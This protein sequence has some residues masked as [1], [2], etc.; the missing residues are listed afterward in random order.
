MP[1]S[2]R[3]F[4]KTTI[5][6]GAGSTL[7]A[8]PAFASAQSKPPAATA[9]A[10]EAAFTRGIGV[11]PGAPGEYFCPTLDIDNTTY[12][13]LALN[14]PAT[15]SSSY[16]Y[17]LTPQLVT[18]GIK[19]ITPPRWISAS[20]STDGVMPKQ[21]RETFLDHWQAN[22][23][24]ILGGQASASIELGGGP[25][26]P[27]A[28]PEVDRIAVFVVIP[29]F[30]S[31][32]KVSITL[33][34]SEDGHSWQ[35][36]GSVTN[37]TPNTET[38]RWPPDLMRGTHILY[39]SIP[40]DKPRRSRFYRVE[41]VVAGA[42]AEDPNITWHLGQIEFYA[43]PN[44]LQIGGPYSFTS[45]WKSA[46]LDE[47]WVAVDLGA[48][49]TFDRVTLHWIARAAAGSLQTS[50]DGETWHTF[51]SLPASAGNI[52][53][54]H[55]APP[56]HARHIRVLMTRPTSPDGYILSEFEVFGRGGP[57]PIPKPAPAPAPTP[58]GRLS[59]AGGNWRLQRENLVEAPGVALSKPTFSDAHWLPA[60]VPGTI[61]T[62]YLNAGAIPDPNF[63]QNQLHISDSFFYA[64]FW[65]RTTFTPPPAGAGQLQ[66]LNFDGI[67]WKAE[68][69]LNGQ[70]LGEIAGGFQRARFNITPHLLPGGDNVLAVRILKNATPGS[71]KQKTFETPGPNG[72]AP[73]ADN[74]T[75]HSSIGWDWIPTI[76]GRNTGIW[77]EVFVETTGTVTLE[78][79]LVSSILTDN[80]KAADVTIRV[81]LV[82]HGSQPA[83]G[84]LQVDFGPIAFGQSV[85]VPP[86]SRITVTLDPS[87]HPKLH[88]EN[89]KLWWPVGYGDPHLYDVSLA[90]D[91]SN[92]SGKYDGFL[93][94]IHLYSDRKTFKAGIRQ[95]TATE[96]GG[97][98]KLFIN[99]R[100]FIPR[101][102]NWGFS[103]SMLR[104]RAREYDAALRY[105][106]EMNFTMIRN[107]VGQIG[108]NAFY[109]ACDRH[110]IVVWQDFWLANPW[111]GPIPDDNALF[112]ANARDTILR[113]RHH[114]SIGLYC[115][116]NEG[117]PPPALETGLRALL[118]ELHPGIHYI[119]SSADDVVSGH[120]PYRALPP[121]T[122]FQHADTKFHS[123]IGM[124][125]IPTLDSVRLMMPTSAM[126]PQGLDWGL[127]D[128]SLNGAQGGRSFRSIID[129]S[130]GGATSAEEWITLAQFVNYEGYRA[131]F[132]AQ[133]R[134][135]MGVLLWMSHPCWP[136]FV[137]QTYDFYLEPTAAYFGCKKASEPLHIQWN[138]LTGF[139]E[140]V[141]LSAGSLTGLTAKVEILNLDGTSIATQTNSLDSPEDSVAPCIK[142]AFP[143]GL[144]PVHFLRLT[145]SRGTAIL[146]TN[147]YLRGLE[148]DNYRAIRELPKAHVQAT[149][150]TVRQGSTWLLT[151]T[152]RNSSK[153]AAL[154]VRLK[155]IRETAGD[156]ILPVI[157]SDNYVTLMPGEQR[158]LTTELNQADTRNQKP[159]ITL[160][161]F[162]IT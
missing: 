139:V 47:E 73:G 138:R 3:T 159:R 1:T 65:Y 148:E 42:T 34:T 25:A 124:P 103:E 143:G 120:G 157:Y 28:V 12:R 110:G 135:R 19:D 10:T 74:P 71:C 96:T 82:N 140:V 27:E 45:A 147:L 152:L 161:G 156:R 146:S 88:I 129:E 46:G 48:V 75:Y 141:N 128:F 11:Y 111:D 137:W 95:M 109:E 142:L 58:E 63:G 132:E 72:G 154:M 38:T 86:S 33:S 85:T 76:R 87:H 99:G 51:H 81:E 134:D 17:N 69:F 113:I 60:T 70:R 121:T 118:A 61:L 26:G 16:D 67:N 56:A 39:P 123:E 108:D 57:I 77:G 41:F 97:A 49:C 79:P 102:G 90:F 117:Y 40:L 100:R 122:Y 54:I 21:S 78:D 44:R 145:L 106:R 130:Y 160:T 68:V 24:T 107:W 31:P 93:S 133:S 91:T 64:D 153:T 127:H 4:L 50:N 114:A 32:A 59:L 125:N 52:D 5:I 7:P 104:Y 80:N 131:I 105:H 84:T 119:G 126:W 144:T 8:I 150:T 2:R 66:W 151:T 9:A 22:T 29:S 6:A 55:L 35:T 20:T 37:P 23:A 92:P 83:S 112:L 43:G 14:R 98:L 149:T 62:S 155:A 158:T 13:N 94:G 115:G 89:P 116:R 36:A 162:N 15:A 136:S 53:D 18:D 30:V 101:G